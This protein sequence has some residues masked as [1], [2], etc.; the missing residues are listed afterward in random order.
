MF[1]KSLLCIE[2]DRKRYNK[3]MN[4]NA[5]NFIQISPTKQG[6]LVSLW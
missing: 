5:Y 3:K 1:K 4:N 6:N 2:I